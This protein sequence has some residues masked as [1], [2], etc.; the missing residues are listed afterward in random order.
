MATEIQL[1]VMAGRAYQSTRNKDSNWFPAPEGWT[2]IEHKT[3]DS[4]FEAVSF[5]RGTGANVEI[6]ISFAG[7]YID[8]DRP[9][10]TSEAILADIALG[11]GHYTDQL[12]DAA[13]YYLQIK[14]ANPNAKSPLPVIP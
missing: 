12:K 13:E 3:K 4:G 8:L 11:N 2:E 6:V 9:I 1:A 14:A 10:E 5:Q 7:T